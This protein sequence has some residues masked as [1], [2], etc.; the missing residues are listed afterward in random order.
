MQSRTIIIDLVYINIK[1][2]FCATSCT[3]Y[4][5]GTL[6]AMTMPSYVILIHSMFSLQVVVL[7]WTGNN[8]TRPL[9][10]AGA[11]ALAPL[12][13]RFLKKTQQV[14]KLPNQAFAFM[15]VVASF[16]SLCFSVVGVLIL[17][18]WGK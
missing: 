10:V 12:I 18:R 4:L 9:R 16:A 11:A 8:V 3:F 1:C 15:I 7:M 13:D 2:F 17:S 6:C 14:L 5:K